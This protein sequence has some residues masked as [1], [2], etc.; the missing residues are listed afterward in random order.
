M[1]LQEKNL[2]NFLIGLF[3]LI[4]GFVLFI[5]AQTIKAGGEMGQGA[6]F[7][8]KLMSGMLGICGIL[9]IIVEGFIKGK[10]KRI[11]LPSKQQLIGFLSAFML[12]FFYIILL[13]SV[14]FLI[15]TALYIFLQS[16]LI[17]PKTKRNLIKQ[18]LIAVISSTVVYFIFVFGLNLML[19]AGILG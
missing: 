8:P 6:D 2:K 19:P 1:N 15:M 5:S 12:L 7:M 13:S 16:W 10:V 18:T 3:L 11:S 17:T 9:V 14:G 4:I